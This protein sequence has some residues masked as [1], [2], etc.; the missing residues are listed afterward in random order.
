MAN[1]Q[2]EVAQLLLF[3]LIGGQSS[4]RGGGFKA[5]AE[6]YHLFVG[7]DLSEI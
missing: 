2:R 7:I 4:G 5:Y 3:G 1:Q 6:K